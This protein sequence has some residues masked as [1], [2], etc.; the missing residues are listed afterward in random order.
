M[1]CAAA[2]L[3]AGAMANACGGRSVRAG[4]SG[5]GPS[6]EGGDGASLGG[7]AG[8]SMTGVGGSDPSC[9]QTIELEP[10]E[11]AIEFLIDSSG[12]LREA[13]VGETSRWQFVREALMG[14]FSSLPN[15]TAAGLVFYPNV[16]WS[17][18]IEGEGDAFCLLTY[19]SAP[20]TP[21]NE[22]HRADLLDAV[23][24]QPALGATP[25]YDAYEYALSLLTRYPEPRAKVALLITDGAPTYADGCVGDGVT[26][27]DATPLAGAARDAFER[28]GIRT[29]VIG[30]SA[31]AESLS[32]MALAGRS[33]RPGCDSDPE[34]GCHFNAVTTAAPAASFLTSALSTVERE[35]RRCV[36]AYPRAE[37][38]ELGGD[39]A[40]LFTLASPTGERILQSIWPP[41]EPCSRGVTHFTDSDRLVL[42]PQTCTEFAANPELRA[43]LRVGCSGR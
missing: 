41:G 37:I 18:G 40:E 1:L 42:C 15:D 32:A 29:F 21:L 14:T 4:G 10:L 23:A 27:V 22:E 26:P 43:E 13:W 28:H 7:A 35:A 34:H 12:S 36:F 33:A 24:Q 2:S 3:V 19:E 30:L 5:A 20:L 6:G 17:A 9:V 38:A 8:T 39:G 25:T 31:G 11:P 16:Q